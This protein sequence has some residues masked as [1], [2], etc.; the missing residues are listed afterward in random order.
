MFLAA[1]TSALSA[2]PQAVQQKVA[3]LSRLSAATCPH[4]EHCWLVYAGLTFSTR[5][6]AFPGASE[7]ALQ[8]LQP[9]PLGV[10]Q[11]GAVQQLAGGQR[12]RH[13]HAAVDADDLASGR[14][15]DELGDGGECDVP[16]PSAV[17]SDAVGLG[18][19]HR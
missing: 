16:A 9:G 12:R 4:A 7:L 1:F 14:A 11:A 17:A 3:W 13:R 5:P 18:C 19:G 15:R 10:T 8:Q 6:G 2:Y